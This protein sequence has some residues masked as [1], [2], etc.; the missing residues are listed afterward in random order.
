MLQSSC[1]KGG[2]CLQYD[3]EV[4]R[5]KIH[6]FGALVRAGSSILYIVGWFV[7]RRSKFYEEEDEMEAQ[8]LDE[9][10]KDK[11]EENGNAVE[12][13]LLNGQREDTE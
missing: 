4:F 6:L 11:K 7:A 8:E 13:K 12:V 3:P 9:M 2:A 1:G 10:T 5:T